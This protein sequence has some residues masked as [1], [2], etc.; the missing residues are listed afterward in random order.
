MRAVINRQA[1]PG[2]GGSPVKGMKSVACTDTNT[3]KGAE[4]EGKQKE[5]R[6]PPWCP[7]LEDADEMDD[8]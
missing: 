5:W 2:I 3:L 6:T 7:L 8:L 1:G 4:A